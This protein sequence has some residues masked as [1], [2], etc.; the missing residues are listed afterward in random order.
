M[1]PRH[2]P[3]AAVA[4]AVVALLLTAGGG[5]WWL[6]G[7]A[8]EVTLT[9]R[10]VDAAGVVSET[11]VILDPRRVGIV[12]VDVWDSHPDP[13]AAERVES[14]V[15]AL[16]RSL[17][18]AR[19]LGM[20]VFIALADVPVE[21]IPGGTPARP[22]R[23]Q[24]PFAYPG[25]TAVSPAY[26]EIPYFNAAEGQTQ[27]PPTVEVPARPLWT[28]VHP[29]LRLDPRD[30]VL[31]AR[32]WW[33][34]DREESWASI[35]TRQLY[36]ESVDRGIT[37]LVYVGVH[38]NWSVFTK[39][40]S[41]EPMQ[42]AGFTVLLA[43]DLSDA[44]TGNGVDWEPVPPSE[45][46][47]LSPD[48]GNRL[49][50]DYV[51]RWMGGTVDSADWVRAAEADYATHLA[52]QP[53]LI[54]YW[55]FEGDAGDQHVQDERRAEGAWL[56]GDATQGIPGAFEGTR[57]LALAGQGAAVVAPLYRADLPPGGPLAVLSGGPTTLEL[58][59]R[60]DALGPP[61]V[62]LQQDGEQPLRVGLD[63][64]GRPAATSGAASVAAEHVVEPGRWHHLAVTF[65]GAA[66][67]IWLD[68]ERVAA[69]ALPRAGTPSTAPILL[70]A[71]G[72]VS[73]EH[74]GTVVPALTAGVTGA[75]DE[76]AV[77]AG[78]LPDATIRTHA[79]AR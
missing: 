63:E 5:W 71:A 78:V 30:V 12:V 49:V 24:M 60:V 8:P 23:P 3:R 44:Y 26:A 36:W 29:D 33:P 43:R 68:G 69:G 22:D 58:W 19:D 56:A 13:V 15:P 31:D 59:F 47:W 62:L 61:V 73:V 2:A 25:R 72:L 32:E 10:R 50:N 79:R 54:A 35:S 18:A 66:G 51:A 57:A 1:M 7:G 39:N 38:T 48:A 76:V 41:M 11:P 21:A 52:S 46:A 9:V 45:A 20:T 65:D 27:V 16:N 28:T 4:A 53:A 6:A 77:Y 14:L 42:R 67:A 74:D 70:G 40:F 75:I 17:D 64:G 34:A 55:R 37:H